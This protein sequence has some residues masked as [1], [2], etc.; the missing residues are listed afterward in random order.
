M[1]HAN[2]TAQYWPCKANPGTATP[3]DRWTGTANTPT[4]LKPW[5][6]CGYVY[7][8]VGG[9]R[10]KGVKCYCL[11][12]SKYHALGTYD[13]WCPSTR[14]EQSDTSN[15]T[16]AIPGMAGY[17][18][19]SAPDNVFLAELEDIQGGD[20]RVDLMF[21]EPEATTNQPKIV[22]HFQAAIPTVAPTTPVSTGL[23]A[24]A[25]T[26]PPNPPQTLY[27]S[28]TAWDTPKGAPPMNYILRKRCPPLR[29]DG[30]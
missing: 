27:S 16:F 9:I 10:P 3:M 8:Q 28:T 15:V 6:T 11:G 20:S 2:H 30:R 17:D 22:D 12:Y 5:G 29:Q 14:A 25:A 23:T 19:A 1:V 4:H 13:M 24:P 7:E 18:V 26:T 21:Q